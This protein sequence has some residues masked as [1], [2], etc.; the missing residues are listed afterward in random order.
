ML[1]TCDRIL[2]VLDNIFMDFNTCTEKSANQ[3]E[4]NS[5]A[6]SQPAEVQERDHVRATNVTMKLTIVTGTMSQNDC[7]NT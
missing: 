6:V 3:N 1:P 4:E 2:A 7:C 5:E